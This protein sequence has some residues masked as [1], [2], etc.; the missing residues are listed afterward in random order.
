MPRTPFI[1]ICLSLGCSDAGVTKFNAKPTA[2]LTSHASGDTVREG[3]AE[4]LRGVVGDPDHSSDQLAVS[5]LIDGVEECPESVPDD[6][7]VVSCEPVF[8]DGGGEVVLEVRDPAGGTGSARLSLVVQP[9]DAPVATIVAP[10]GSGIYYSDQLTTLEGL[11][12]DTEDAAVELIVVWES[13]LGGVLAGAF[14]TPDSEGT[15]L[16]ALELEEGEHFL[17]LTVTDSTGKEGRDSLTFEVGPPNTAP[18]CV[19]TAPAPNS[20]GAEGELVTFTGEVTDPDVPAD[21]L[22]VSW[23]SDKDGPLGDSTPN[24]S[25]GVTFPFSELSLDTH[26]VT[27]TVADEVGDTCAADVVYTVGEPPELVLTSPLDG[28][29]INETDAVVFVGTVSDREDTADEVLLTWTSDRDG[30][31]STQGADTLGALSFSTDALSPGAHAL[32]IR[33]TDTDGLYAQ[34]SLGVTINQVPTAPTVTIAPDPA[35]TDDDLFASASGSVDPDGSGTVTYAYAWYVDGVLST[36]STSATF[37]ATDTAKKHTYRVVVHPSDGT[38]S[39]ASGEAE[40]TVDNSSPVLSGPTLSASTAVVGDT[41]TCTA[42]ATDADG[43]SLTIT[44]AWPD[45]SSGSTYT[46]ADTD[47]P[48]DTITCTATVDDGDGGADSGTASA[49]V[50]NTDPVLGTVSLSAATAK[51][52]DTLTCSA[53]A[54]DADGGTP[55]VSYTWSGGSSGPTYTVVDTDDPGDTVT[56]TATAEDLNGG[57]DTGTASATVENTD[58][59]LG[60]VAISPSSANNDTTLT[61]SAS[62]TDADG[63]TPTLSYAW[64]GSAAGSLGSSA[65]IDLSTTGAASAETVTCTVTASDIDAG[66]AL[67]TADL[68]LDNRDPVVSVSLSPS[69]G[70]TR[71]DTLICTAT[72]SDADD[73]ALTTTFSWTV[74]GSGVAASSTSALSSTLEGAFGVGESVVC[75]GEADDLKGG[76]HS[77]SAS[78]TITNTAPIVGTVSL[79]PTSVTTDDTL[80]ASVSPAPSDL[81]GDSLTVTYDWYVG[82]VSVQDGALDTLDGVSL[83]DKNDTVYVVVAADDG[84]DE[85]TATSSTVTVS[86]SPP[87]APTIS[88]EETCNSVSFDGVDDL[89][90]VTDYAGTSLGTSFT[91]EA[92]VFWDGTDSNRYQVIA[93]QT[94][95][96]ASGTHEWMFAVATSSST[97]CGGGYSAGVLL[98]DMFGG[99]ACSHST[100]ALPSD[101]WAH[102]AA[103]YS[104]GQTTLFIDGVEGTTVTRSATRSQ[105][106]SESLTLGW[107]S[108]NSEDWTFDGDVD[109]VRISSSARY[110]ADFTTELL[111]QDSDTLS[112]WQLDEGSGTTSIDPVGAADADLDGPTWIADCMLPSGLVCTVDTDS[113]DDDLDS[114]AYTFS[115]EDPAGASYTDAVGTYESGDTVEG[116]DLDGRETWTCTVTPHDGDDA[117]TAASQSITTVSRCD[118]DGDGYDASTT[119]CG[120]IDCDDDDATSTTTATDA[121]CDG[122][123]TADDCDDSDDSILGGR[124]VLEFAG[125]DKATVSANSKL[126][127]S[128][129]DSFTVSYWANYTSS[130]EAT[131]IKGSNSTKEYGIQGGKNN[132]AL[133]RQDSG[134][135]ATA[136]D[137]NLL[138]DWAQYTVVY[139]AGTITFYLDGT[140]SGSGSGSI[141]SSSSSALTLGNHPDGSDPLN[142]HLAELVIWNQAHSAAD[143]ADY[144][145]GTYTASDLSGLVAHWAMDEGTGSTAYDGSG[146]SLNA[147]ISGAAWTEEC[148]Y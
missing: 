5:W 43:D 8:A 133:V 90:E 11:V 24:S 102:V 60:T 18:S 108:D 144:V 124:W 79:T 134:V 121:D 72:V 101:D 51:V 2:E 74:A 71:A 22:S 135:L 38:G 29:V 25:G 126:N 83:F 13:S 28:D 95:G 70:A 45:G 139:D 64:S 47:D 48:G 127:F 36:A 35:L 117:G 112:L 9:T 87:T 31:F 23:E 50:D 57:T 100:A 15:L 106:G 125:S 147:S 148:V 1:V 104:G 32:T 19:L 21:W 59:V 140:N 84:T 142:G 76:T 10:S 92:W 63:G 66:S 98:W 113:T 75:T 131:L 80:T 78:T 137:A 53:S 130:S 30:V 56:C 34:T 93:A 52:G 62:A 145:D 7:G 33:A 129:S 20:A 58:P 107:G 118:E 97:A 49:T 42:T 120:G 119:E 4:P 69:S 86:N 67:G 88:V 44:Y 6:S 16:G 3:F 61:C 143:I 27:M 73:D 65:S 17:T 146:N 82:G 40:V 115:W 99:G 81:D 94:S 141:G 85:T 111:T 41:L 122:Y 123:E 14:D 55:T 128:S 77:A 116:V 114:I 96:N 132:V 105:L 138:N 89:I 110:T 103:V 39:G 26:V 46:V 12:S 68:T 136:T 54:T 37:S 91:V 109:A